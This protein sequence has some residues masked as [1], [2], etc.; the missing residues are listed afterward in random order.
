MRRL[1]LIALGMV[2]LANGAAM[3]L[4]PFYW[5]ASVPGVGGTGP[6]NVHFV[7]D[8]GLAFL[9][10]GASLLASA[11]RPGLAVLAWPGAAFLAGHSAYHLL[12]L[13][14]GHG[15]GLVATDVLGIHLPALAALWAAARPWTAGLEDVR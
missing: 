2:A 3:I 15:A 12:L 1:V 10:A 7:T 4:S 8:V 14:H 6:L 5:Y 13:R 9:V 11:A